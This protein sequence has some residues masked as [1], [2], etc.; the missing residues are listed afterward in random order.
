MSEQTD[1]T[2][3]TLIAERQRALGVD[4]EALALAVGYKP[5]VIAMIKAGKMRLPI[6]KVPT[7]AHALQMEPVSLLRATMM[8][9]SPELWSVLELLMPLGQLAPA[10]VNLLRH[11]REVAAGRTLTPL[12]LDGASV[13]ALVVAQ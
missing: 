5:A 1:L 13:V 4:D 6:N 11:L 8:Q 3:E 12:V 2:P 7:F 10:E 9:A